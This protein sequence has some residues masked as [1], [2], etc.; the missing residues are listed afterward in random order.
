MERKVVIT[1]VKK[2]K[3]EQKRNGG[4][5][6]GNVDAFSSRLRRKKS[7]QKRWFRLR[8]TTKP[9]L[10]E[11]GHSREGSDMFLFLSF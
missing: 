6:E 8:E 3:K 1:L 2:S 4:R 11:A 5:A 10:L 9:F 7:L